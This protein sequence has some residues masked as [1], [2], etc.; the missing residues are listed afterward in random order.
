MRRLLSVI[1]V[2][3]LLLLVSSLT[4]AD[5][6]MWLYNAVP[7]NKIK[8]KYKFAPDQK[9]LDHLRLASLNVGGASASFVSADGLV[10]TNHHVGAGCVHNVS[11]AEHDYIKDGF[12]AGTRENEPKCPGLV[13]RTLLDIRDITADVQGAVKPGM[14]D[15]EAGAAQRAETR[16]LERECS[17]PTNNIRCDTVTLYSGS[18]Y[19]LYK[20][21]VYNDIRLVM[22]P[23]YDIAFFGGDSDNFTYPRY[24]LDITFFRVYENN[25]PVHTEYLTWSTEGA[26]E[27][28]LIFVSGNPGSTGRL[29]TMAQLEYL[30]DVAYPASL[31]ALKRNINSL[32]AFS[33]TSPE[34][35]RAAERIL[36][37]SQ[38]SYKAITGYQSGLLD[39]NI[40]AQKA[41]AERK[42]REAVAAN[43]KLAGE[44]GP[45]WDA[46]A[47]ALQW[48]RDNFK[49]ITFKGEGAVPGR[50]AG[51]ARTLVRVADERTKPNEKRMAG[52]QD[53]NLPAIEQSLT[54]NIPYSPELEL[55]QVT[56]GLRALAENLPADDPFLKDVLAGKSP[57]DRARELVDGSH[58]SDVAIR[59]QLFS[60]GQPAIQASTDPMI[61]LIRKIDP[62]VRQMRREMEDKVDSAVRK[63]GAVIAKARFEIY[64]NDFPPDA[65]GTLRLSYGQVKGYLE[66]GKKVPAFTTIGGVFD[67]EKK[68]N[69][70]APYKLPASWHRALAA[71]GPAKLDLNTPLDSVN[72]SDIIGGNSG[73]PAVNKD[74]DVVGIL[75]DGNIQS[76]PW[77]FYFEDEVGRSVLTD[78]RAVIETLRKIYDAGP[79]ADEILGARRF[80]PTL[81]PPKEK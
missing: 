16:L 18:L 5:E 7:V 40:M 45:A 19:H 23:E 24:D 28:D 30:R 62:E 33:A 32:L 56:D 21:H 31:A 17:D 4:L 46:I 72:T 35:A 14:S 74:G 50:L 58:L 61:Q 34:N 53:Q 6:G 2:L 9:W 1:P 80:V 27:G 73:S 81:Y 67:L 68:H 20:Y 37:G 15:A 41:E 52:F 76:L 57:E 38:N 29:L 47:Q 64:G 8:A 48:Q 78:S 55:M 69:G 25:Q 49:R 51:I 77:R 44:V 79:L 42:L 12:Y 65:T 59:K 66:N 11:T 54:A 75:F 63:Y 71:T 3:V 36:F 39:K 60:G 70:L 10:F 13:M 43:P 22:A 26:K